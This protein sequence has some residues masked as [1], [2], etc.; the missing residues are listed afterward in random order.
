ML[1]LCIGPVDSRNI[2]CHEP[3]CPLPTPFCSTLCGSWG[4]PLSPSWPASGWSPPLCCRA[5]SWAP[6]PCRRDSRWGG[7]DLPG[8]QVLGSASWT[9]CKGPRACAVQDLDGC[10]DDGC[11]C[12]PMH[13]LSP[14]LPV[15]QIAGI[16]VTI[17]SVTAFMWWSF[18]QAQRRQAST[19]GAA[20]EVPPKSA[21][22]SIEEAAIGGKEGNESSNASA[23][24]KA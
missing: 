12:Q 20:T 5:S 23:G 24:L 17:A 15:S 9:Y 1:P 6:A 21:P 4:R 18:R 13:A 3:P 2:G 8:R 16:A 22:S 7:W 19:P 14:C 10:V 11:W